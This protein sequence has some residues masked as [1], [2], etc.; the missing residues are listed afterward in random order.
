MSIVKT[1]AAVPFDVQLLIIDAVSM[2]GF[3]D[4][5]RTCALICH[6]WLSRARRHLYSTIILTRRRQ[7]M[8]L[9][10]TIEDTPKLG[11]LVLDLCLILSSAGPVP[12]QW[13]HCIPFTPHAI[14]LLTS[15]RLVTFGCYFKPMP[16]FFIPLM[17]LFATCRTVKTLSFLPMHFSAFEDFVRVIVSFPC[18][19]ALYIAGCD[20]DMAGKTIEQ[21]EYSEHC[22][23]L[24]DLKVRMI[25]SAV[26]RSIRLLRFRRSH[27]QLLGVRDGTMLLQLF[28]KCDVTGIEWWPA[29]AQKGGQNDSA[30][31]SSCIYLC[32]Q[33]LLTHCDNS[34]VK[35]RN[36]RE[37]ATTL[38]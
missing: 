35:I 22:K 26:G 25:S 27:I 11:S 34:T 3:T 6:A 18:V 10:R 15:L 37:S 5:L 7:F 29:D 38:P 9:S 14:T 13:H 20:W 32:H 1:S 21:S 19:T 12:G 4:V 28:V 17:H 23:S 16:A 24:R 2:L 31:Q 8:L 33:Y 36:A 30:G